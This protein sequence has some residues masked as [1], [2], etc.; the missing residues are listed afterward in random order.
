MLQAQNLN[1]YPLTPDPL[2]LERTLWTLGLEYWLL[3]VTP[4]TPTLKPKHQYLNPTNPQP[5][6]LHPKPQNPKL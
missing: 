6:T 3:N 4:W 1:L 2:A 5:Y